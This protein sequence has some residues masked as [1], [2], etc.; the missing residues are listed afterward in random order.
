MRVLEDPRW[1][2]NLAAPYHT[3]RKVRPVVTGF[4]TLPSR[5]PLYFMGK[6][7]QQNSSQCVVKWSISWSQSPQGNEEKLQVA[8]AILGRTLLW[9]DQNMQ[10]NFSKAWPTDIFLP[11]KDTLSPVQQDW[12]LW[13]TS[14]IWRNNVGRVDTGK[15]H[16]TKFKCHAG[17][18]LS[19]WH[20][21]SLYLILG[22]NS[23]YHTNSVQYY[24]LQLTNLPSSFPLSP[25]LCLSLYLSHT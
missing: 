9:S 3:L 14:G 10:A 12:H 25:F 21:F 2:S 7:F 20:S 13:P 11:V 16:Q 22:V 23:A 18:D 8:C 6:A 1:V 17:P 4:H 5:I 15:I 24:S 19:P